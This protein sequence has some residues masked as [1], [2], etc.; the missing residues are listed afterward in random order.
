MISVVS[1]AHRFQSDAVEIE[2][3]DRNVVFTVFDGTFSVSDNITLEI[4]T[5]DDNPTMVRS[6]DLCVLARPLLSVSRLTQP[7]SI[8][9]VINSVPTYTI[10]ETF[11]LFGSGSG[12]DMSLGPE[13]EVNSIGIGG[14]LMLI[15]S[16][17]VNSQVYVDRV[18]VVIS[19]GSSVERLY[20]NESHPS[21]QVSKLVD[22]SSD[23]NYCIIFRGGLIGISV[24]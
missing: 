6:P 9:Q 14:G 20:F 10:N 21:I 24:N 5:I 18:V 8:D 15:D 4:Q 13:V 2:S 12:Q 23:L 22:C 19:D 7:L 11:S 17:S 16:D 1:P 3:S